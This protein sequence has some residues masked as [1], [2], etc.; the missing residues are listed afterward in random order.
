M[1]SCQQLKR[2]PYFTGEHLMQLGKA[3]ALRNR[4]GLIP[5]HLRALFNRFARQQRFETVDEPASFSAAPDSGFLARGPV[6]RCS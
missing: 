5:G 1:F 2:A 4:L 6:W 3:A